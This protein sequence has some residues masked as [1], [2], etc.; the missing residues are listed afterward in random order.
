MIELLASVLKWLLRQ[1]LA[2]VVILTLLVG[3]AWVEGELKRTD[4]LAKERAASRNTAGSAFARNHGAEA[5]C[6]RALQEIAVLRIVPDPQTGRAAKALG[7]KLLDALHP[8]IGRVERNQAAR[9]RDRERRA[10]RRQRCPGK[11]AGRKKA[12]WAGALQARSRPADHRARCDTCYVACLASHSN[13]RPRA[14]HCSR[15][16]GWNP[17]GSARYQGIPVFRAGALGNEPSSDAT[18][19]FCDRADRSAR[20]R[21][22]QGLGGIASNR[23]AAKPGTA[24]SGRL[25]PKHVL[26]GE[27]RDEVA[28]RLA[29][30]VREP[31]L[32]DVSV[33][34]RQP[35]GRRAGSPVLDPRSAERAWHHRRGGRCCIRRA[36]ARAGWSD[37]GPRQG[38]SG[39]HATGAWDCKRG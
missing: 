2:L 28:A 16:T 8:G 10:D 6:A 18:A 19:A 24:R 35:G 4:Q 12:R 29:H 26:A 22:R 38:R 23:P 7:R 3:F 27:E 5:G 15:D 25:P 32:G 34:A 14:S 13:R 31:A 9:R 30:S 36:A 21:R 1:S 20:N 17:A 33:D 37:P 39:S 11:R